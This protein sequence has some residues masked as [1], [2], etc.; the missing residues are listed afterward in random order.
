MSKS[1][2]DAERLTRNFEHRLIVTQ[3]I[4][5]GITRHVCIASSPKV[6]AASS[7]L[8]INSC[9]T[10]LN[11]TANIDPLY[12]KLNTIRRGQ[13]SNSHYNDEPCDTLPYAWCLRPLPRPRCSPPTLWRE[14][15]YL[16]TT[17]QPLCIIISVSR[18]VNNKLRNVL[19][20]FIY[21][22]WEKTLTR[23]FL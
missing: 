7:A 16:P 10:N 22:Y 15:P 20:T 4:D 23:R 18:A 8:A 13:Y 2:R 6:R 9:E 19:R 14:V 21:K 12:I 1:Y 5:R 11:S 17:E 3:G